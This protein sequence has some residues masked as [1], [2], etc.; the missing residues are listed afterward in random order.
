MDDF[1]VL[2]IEDCLVGGLTSLLGTFKVCD[3]TEEEIK[4]LA[5]ESEECT[6]ERH[7]LTSKLNVLEMS[8]KDLRRLGTP[9]SVESG[10]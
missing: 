8:V 7:R 1:S 3:M 6:T 4:T 10:K 2:A 9:R 5:E